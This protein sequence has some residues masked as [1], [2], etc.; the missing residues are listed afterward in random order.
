MCKTNAIETHKIIF[1]NEEQKM[2]HETAKAWIYE[3]TKHMKQQ[4]AKLQQKNSKN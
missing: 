3:E 2:K 1:L 4:E